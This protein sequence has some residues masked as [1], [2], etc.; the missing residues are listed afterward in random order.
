MHEE[1]RRALAPVMVDV[2][3]SGGPVPVVR[4]EAWTDDPSTVT[5][6][7]DGPKSS[8][9]IGLTLGASAVDAVVALADQVQGWVI[10][11]LRHQ[12]APTNRP[13]CSAHP[14]QHPMAAENRD[15]TATWSCPAG[16][17][18]GVVIGSLAN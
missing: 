11:E 1:L 3:A 10:E 8:T 4:D 12:A 9:G 15:G 6:V 2:R 5:A 14:D 7:L 13:P 16:A 18:E 17:V